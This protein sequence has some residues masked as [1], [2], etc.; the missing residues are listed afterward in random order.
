LCSQ[1]PD[2]IPA[3]VVCGTDRTTR[4]KAASAGKK[5]TAPVTGGADDDDVLEKCFLH[6]SGMTCSSCVANIE[7]RLLRVQGRLFY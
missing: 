7:G 4:L 5:R 3:V 2:A 6:V 1:Q